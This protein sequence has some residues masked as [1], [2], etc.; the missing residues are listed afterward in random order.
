MKKIII[1]FLT[2]ILFG[3]AINASE[4]LYINEISFLKPEFVEIYSSNYLN[5]SE[6]L[7]YD[8][9]GIDKANTLKLI[10]N[11]DS[12][13]YLIVG[14]DFLDGYDISQINATI[15]ETQKS[16]LGYYG[17]KDSGENFTITLNST[18]NLIWPNNQEYEFEENQTLNYNSSSKDYFIANSSP[19]ELS[20]N[21]S[22]PV[23][24]NINITNESI[25]NIT[26][27]ISSCNFSFKIIPYKNLTFDKIEFEFETNISDFQIEYWI[28]SYLGNIVKNKRNTTNLDMKTYTPNSQ[29]ELYFIKSNL[30]FLNCI[31]NDSKLITYYN[32]NPI[33]TNSEEKSSSSSSSSNDNQNKIS[34]SYIIILNELD[35]LNGS[36]NVLKYEIYKGNSQKR[37]IYFY[38]NKEKISSFELEKYSKIKGLIEFKEFN[39]NNTL[40]IE[41]LDLKK[42]FNFLRNNSQNIMPAKKSLAY[43][44]KLQIFS[45]N[46]S[47][48]HFNIANISQNLSVL[49]YVNNI[50]TKV[51]TVLNLSSNKSSSYFL[52]INDTKLKETKEKNF[53]LKLYCKYKKLGL[54]TYNYLSQNFTYSIIQNSNKK[55]INSTIFDTY[56][57]NSIQYMSIEK[58]QDSILTSKPDLNIEENI[59]IYTSD[60]SNTKKSS[61]FYVFLAL[62]LIVIVFIVLW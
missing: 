27:N 10:N 61:I 6:K 23:N 12:N 25:Q 62:S 55:K 31:L 46:N 58:S 19:G 24:S 37:T 13:I 59:T 33:T 49:C 30:Y 44:P 57:S 42:E 45:I 1:V 38:L 41:G 47:K 21:L 11:K 15:Y 8:D 26:T 40:V 3:K 32:K 34:Q 14:D 39:Y 51:S 52:E 35:F 5:F 2:I 29:T 7:F 9:G 48:L 54:K 43:S 4:E 17:L 60:R 22:L 50:R 28:E 36:T 18:L 16:G 56:N 53:N 20:Q